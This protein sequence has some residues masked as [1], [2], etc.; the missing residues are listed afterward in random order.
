LKRFDELTER[1]QAR[2]LRPLAFAALDRYGLDVRRVSLLAN[3]LNAVFRVDTAE[4]NKYALRI[5]TPGGCHGLEE[6]RSELAWL[7][8]L[9]RD[10]RIGVPR[11]IPADDGTLVRTVEAEGVPGARHCVVFGWVP[12]VDMAERLTPENASRLGRLTAL[13]HG[14]AEFFSPPEGFRVRT[15]DKVF[16]YADADFPLVE[17]IALFEEPSR[18]LLT[19]RTRKVYVRAVRCVQHALEELLARQ[20]RMRIVHNDL[21]PWN[22]KVCRGELYAM[23]FEE[24]MWGYPVQDIATTLYYLWLQPTYPALRE[25]YERGYRRLNPWPE[26]YPGEIDAF[27]A[28]RALILVNY[29]L[30]SG[31]MRHREMAPE[32]VATV[33]ERLETLLG[34]GG[35]YNSG[36]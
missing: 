35:T 33:A 34:P 13:L 3:D 36:T 8:E 32:Y 7:T 29:V 11:P 1:G 5:S 23:D 16:P 19:R 28:D 30:A 27:M 20:E 24:L 14:H 21:H 18:R 12:G 6:I 15:L 26:R 2:R 17:R 4:G 9:E 10:P 31:A 22:V 25:G